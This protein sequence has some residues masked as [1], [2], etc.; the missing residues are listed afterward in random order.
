[1]PSR[2]MPSPPSTVT[3]VEVSMTQLLS[4]RCSRRALHGNQTRPESVEPGQ[5]G[6]DDRAEEEPFRRRERRLA[7]LAFG[8]RR[9]RVRMP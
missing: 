3:T 9:T 2:N 6:D 1:M 8:E 4:A 7:A 5:R